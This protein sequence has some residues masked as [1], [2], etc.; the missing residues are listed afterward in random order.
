MSTHEDTV[1][2]PGLLATVA[3]TRNF[4]FGLVVGAV[5][6]AGVYYAYIHSPGQSP[7]DEPQYLGLALVL[8]VSVALLLGIVLSV[9]T[10]I[11][12]GSDDG[13]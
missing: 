8:G 10:L 1:E 11:R 4:G 7:L 12:R 2:G 3:A 13:H 5:L 6:A 9:A